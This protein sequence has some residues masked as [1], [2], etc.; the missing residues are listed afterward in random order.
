MLQQ[1]HETLMNVIKSDKT[2]LIIFVL[3]NTKEMS[4]Q[5]LSKIFNSDILQQH[6]TVVK[7]LK[8]NPISETNIKKKLKNII[9]DQQIILSTNLESIVKES[10]KDMRNAIQTLQFYATGNMGSQEDLRNHGSRRKK[11]FLEA[12]PTM[13]QKEFFI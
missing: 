9:N 6:E 2:N 13:T 3:S 4:K 8:M 12:K 5:F 7:I 1:F 11:H 10:C